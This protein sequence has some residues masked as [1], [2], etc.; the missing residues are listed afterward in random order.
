MRILTAAFDNLSVE[1]SESSLEQ[2]AANYI[3]AV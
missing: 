2:I 3:G 1:E